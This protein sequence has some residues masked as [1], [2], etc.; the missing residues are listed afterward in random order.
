MFFEVYSNLWMLKNRDEEKR[1]YGFSLTNQGLAVII[2]LKKAM[3]A[4]PNLLSL[5]F[6]SRVLVVETHKYL[7]LNR[8]DRDM[9]D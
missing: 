8:L 6:L 7:W 5:L 2:P 1:K 3:M 9:G 4:I